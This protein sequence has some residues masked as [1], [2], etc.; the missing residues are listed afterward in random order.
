MALLDGGATCAALPEEVALAIIGYALKQVE[1]GR[2]TDGSRTNPLVRLQRLVKR[3]RI[4][5]VAAGAPIQMTYTVALRTEFVPTGAD[6]GPTKDLCFKVFPK[7]TCQV[8]RV[9]I[10]FPVLDAEP[11]GL[12]LVTQPTTH[13]FS[14]LKISLP[15][16]ELERRNQYIEAKK[17]NYG[18]APQAV[19]CEAARRCMEDVVPTVW[20]LVAAAEAGNLCHEPAGKVVALDQDLEVIEDFWSKENVS[21][22]STEVGARDQEVPLAGACGGLSFCG[23]GGRFNMLLPESC[24]LL[25]SQH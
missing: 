12:G 10:G 8:P 18:L 21:H 14:A 15:R 7:G 3:P 19:G 13:F 11:Y 20:N 1:T 23:E 9:I 6:S 24:E 22:E 25:G 2:Y 17:L 5:G 16:L 4:D